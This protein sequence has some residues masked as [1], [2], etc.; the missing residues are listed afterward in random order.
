MHSGPAVRQSRR[1]ASNHAPPQHLP[2][3]KTFTPPY[4]I[5]LPPPK[6]IKNNRPIRRSPVS[7]WLPHTAKRDINDG[8]VAVE[9]TGEFAGKASRAEKEHF[10]HRQMTDR[11]HAVLQFEDTRAYF[12]RAAT[13]A[14]IPQERRL[15]PSI[16]I[17]EDF[18]LISKELPCLLRLFSAVYSPYRASSR[19]PMNFVSVTCSRPYISMRLPMPSGAV[20][21]AGPVRRLSRDSP[22]QLLH[23]N[24]TQGNPGF[25]DRISRS[26]LT[27]AGRGAAAPDSPS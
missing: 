2:S 26:T 21:S 27:S 3:K 25:L 14:V 11:G 6:H 1:D 8:L 10:S 12:L 9:G 20:M 5:R 22:S 23:S 19:S 16:E 17:V 24:S 13:H 4:G 15:L 7:L 18:S